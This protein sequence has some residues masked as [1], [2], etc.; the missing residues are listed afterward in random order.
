MSVALADKNFATMRATAA[1]QG[2]TLYR[3]DPVDGPVVYFLER[4]G[5]VQEKPVA[6]L[7]ELLSLGERVQ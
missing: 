2:L 3:T 6:D 1:L 7:A 5:L 4:F